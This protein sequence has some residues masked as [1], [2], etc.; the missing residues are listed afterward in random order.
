MQKTKLKNGITLIIK[1]RPSKSVAINISIKTGSV[2]ETTNIL[3]ISHVIEHMLFEGTKKRTQKEIVDEIEKVGGEINA[4][5]STQ[6]TSYYAIVLKKHFQKALDVLSDMIQNPLF[7]KKLIEKEKKVILEEIKIIEDQPR[8]YQWVLFQKTLFKEH[9]VKN[10]VYG[11]HKTVKNITKDQIEEYYNKHY[12][13]KN[14]II[15]V[16]GNI[17]KN[18]I[19]T[20]VG[21]I[22][23][24]IKSLIE[25]AFKDFKKES[26]IEP[27]KTK[28]PK[29]QLTKKIIKRNTQHSYIVLGYKTP[30]RLQKDS[31]ALDLLKVILGYGQSSKLFAE[32]RSKLGLAYEISA[33]H[34][35]SKDYG[36]F[37]IN[38][39]TDKQN[40]NKVITII[41]NEFKKIQKYTNKELNEAKTQIEGLFKLEQE[42]NQKIAELLGFYEQINSAELA[43]KYIKNIKKVT[44][45]QL[46]EVAK[47]YLNG[48]YALTIIKQK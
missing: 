24:N 20:V 12:T 14:I 32:I 41:L 38:L 46:K 6:H 39:S 11:T 44:L 22:P 8:S 21:N 9:P 33:E 17:P 45:K 15:T 10:P 19:I 37:A 43:E 7:E 27:L 30:N 31:Y 48:N 4:L 29:N 5:T 40:I 25:T 34:E 18:I 23:K 16:V 35:T 2:N 42:N 1:K 47:T 3:G 26:K 28:E 36:F 13:P